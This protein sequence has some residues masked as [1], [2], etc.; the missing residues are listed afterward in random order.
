[1]VTLIF[2]NTAV[3]NTAMEVFNLLDLDWRNCFANLWLPTFCE[4]QASELGYQKIAQL[5]KIEPLGGRKPPQ[6][7]ASI[8]EL[9]R[10]WQEG[11]MTFANIFLEQLPA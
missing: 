5:Q 10:R 1:M 2:T 3:F 4:E 11:N 8:L 6:L 7:L 9:C